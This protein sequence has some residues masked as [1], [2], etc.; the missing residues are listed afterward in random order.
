MGKITSV[1]KGGAVKVKNNEKPRL[2]SMVN[3]ELSQ[4]RETLL[5]RKSIVLLLKGTIY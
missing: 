4:N 5:S 1:S 3:Y 2:L